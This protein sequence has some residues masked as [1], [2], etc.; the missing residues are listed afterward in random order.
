MKGFLS[1]LCLRSVKN[2]PIKFPRAN[3]SAN[4]ARH[5]QRQFNDLNGRI[6]LW[7]VPLCTL[8]S[9]IIECTRLIYVGPGRAAGALEIA[10]NL[11]P[12][13]EKRC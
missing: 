9:T 1:K 7:S 6:F 13:E 5:E 8:M 10:A 2:D 12:V 3:K 11:T 4:K